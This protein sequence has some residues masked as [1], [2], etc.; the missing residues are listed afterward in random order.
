MKNT[1]TKYSQSIANQASEIMRQ[2]KI[3]QSALADRMN[4]TQQYASRL[5]SGREN[6][7]LETIALLEDALG[8]NLLSP[9]YSQ[10]T[11]QTLLMEEGAEYGSGRTASTLISVTSAGPTVR[12]FE[13]GDRPMLVICDNGFKYLCKSATFGSGANNLARELTGTS[14]AGLWGICD[15]DLALVRILPEHIEEMRVNCNTTAPGLGRI[16]IDNAVEIKDNY[17]TYIEQDDS[18]FSNLLKIALFD[19]WLCNE[20]R[21]N[22][23]LNLLYSLQ[24]NRIVAIDHAGIF[25]TSFTTPLTPLEMT[26]SVL[27]SNLFAHLSKGQTKN[28]KKVDEPVSFFL[29]ITERCKTSVEEIWNR[30]PECWSIDKTAFFSIMDFIFSEKWKN[31]TIDRFRTILDQI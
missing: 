28:S 5:L 15:S 18:L 10:D 6:M 16:W 30:I 12:F 1:W 19:L 27:Y 14:F 17:L 29:D 2:R 3:T 22:N 11:A 31:S 7:T 21:L 4:R 9:P 20:D 8:I 26:D 25:N 13:T 24:D 23:N